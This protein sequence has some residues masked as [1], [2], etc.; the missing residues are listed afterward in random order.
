MLAKDI[1]RIIL[2]GVG[3]SSLGAVI[4]FAGPFVAFG[5]WRPLENHI[6]RQIAIL[7]L[8]AAVASVAG[9][10]LFKRRKNAKEIAD[11]ISGVDQPVSDEPVLKE[12]M[13]DAL[14]T[15]KTASGNK[16]GY[17]YDLP[18][19]VI[20]GPPG[21]GKTTA[22]VNS[23]LKFPLARGATPAAIAGVGGTRYCDW[24][25]TEEAVLI[26]TAGRYTTQDS[27]SKVDKDSWL[28][29]LDILK[30]SRSRQPIN[31]VLVAI[32]IEDVLTLPKQELALHADAIRMRLLELHQRLKVSFPVYAL[33]TKA[34]LVAGF[35]EYFAYLGE[36][37]RRQVWG[38]TFQTADKTQ[39]LVGQIP[40]EFDRLLER[41]SE[42]T[43]DRL[44]D[45]PTAQHRVQLFGFPA[46]MARLKPQIHNFLNQ[47]FEPTRYHVNAN[48]RGFYFTSGTQQ[49]TPIDQLIGSLART[50]GAEEVS[51]GSYSGT[52]K[53]YFLADL[54]S[55]VIIGEADWVSTDR[56][57]VRRALI[58]KTAALSFIGLVSIG[59]IAVWVTS[60]K[61][62]S[63]LIEQS[64]QADAEYAAAGSPLIKQTLIADHDL[65]KVLPLLYRLR[66]APAGYGSRVEPVP[67]SA[68]YGLSQHTRLLSPSKAAYHTALE[69]MFRPRL[70]YRLE[71]QLNA[72]I[73]EP[74]FVYEALKVYLMLGGLQSPDREL[75]R[76][77]MQRDWADNLYPGATN[78]EGRRLLDENLMAMFDLE[79]EQPPLVG[80]DGR[81]I[82]QAQ[83]SL[84]RLSVSQRAYEFLKSEARAST[85]GDW[86]VSRRGGPD[87]AIVFETTT[88]QPLDTVRV[89]EFFT[90][91]G[92]HQK[93]I[94]RL[95]GLSERMKR[96]RWVLGDA[97]QQSAIDQQYDSLA[98]D[99]LNVYSNEFVTTWR[100]ALGSLRLKKL[101]A[102]KPKYEVLRA[103]SAPTSPMRQILESVRDET[104]LTKERPK[105]ANATAPAVA[106]AAS[107]PALFTNVQDGPPGAAIEAQFKP[108]H[109]VLE[110][111][112]THR[113]I[114]S[115]IANLND[116]AQN[117]TLIV[118]NP[119]LTA[120]A[121]T[122][123]Q[124]QVAALRN[125]ASRM[126]P[127]FS[128]MLRAAAAEFEGSIAASTAG[129]I[130]Q[131]LRD[132]VTPVCQQAVTNRYPFVRGSNQEVP[133]AD[134]AKLFSPN[135][136]MDKFFAQFL[137]PYADTSR[138][139]WVWRKESPVGRSFSPDTLKQF[140]NAAYIRDA[141]FQTGGGVP[142]V[143]LAIRPPGAAGPGVTIKTEI[144]GTTITSPTTPGPATSSMF[145]APQPPPSPPQSN[146]PTT[147]LWP[148]PSPRTAIS[149]S[150]DSGPPSV[151]ERNGPWSLFRMLEAGSLVAKA[152]T[153]S[154]TFIVAGRELNYQISTGSMRNPLNLTV[155][156]EFRCPSGI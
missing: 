46:Q 103:L 84:A 14:A 139:E 20:I 113:P 87:V 17:L 132:Q 36:A 88:G 28:A 134:F 6:V 70:L 57:A 27:N 104:M 122:A 78:A 73:E 77:W 111:E 150:N 145:G 107:A 48:L 152:E 79:T 25:F 16:S 47:I 71:E 61:R 1:L 136:I 22:L 92:F 66:N 74:A 49:G 11:G 43:L 38:A 56:A 4:Y 15:L 128:D 125:N 148:G 23:G 35:T 55:K 26:D 42:E 24:W 60:Y 5:D 120:Q 67:L 76:S 29:F 153:A 33:F 85:A 98:G 130:L 86:I 44:Q 101:L 100:T 124:T 110:G 3:L 34:D 52:G 72:R 95:P 147:V 32:S 141:F 31:G 89:P 21:A 129:Q 37:G 140:Q 41:L 115:T 119:Q 90:Y 2:Y 40:V 13:K 108:Y 94:A 146:A 7:L 117:L 96:E 102:D 133:L 64:L 81:L 144:G 30:K 93:F 99:L 54:I 68:R 149:V 121:T 83:N 50:F 154:A 39:N 106:P 151:L 69:R 138:P 112:S 109:A 116:I 105:P 97:G 137:S 18:W 143:S 156:R 51:A 63:D 58:L 12:R 62:N 75:I 135:G 53:S 45:E 142:A 9:L 65:D 126:P 155:L 91:N 114:D 59:L 80:L 8:G 19:Y 127:P 131:S 10:H 123:L 118:E 82:K